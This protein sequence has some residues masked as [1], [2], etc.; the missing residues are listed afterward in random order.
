VTTILEL[1]LYLRVLELTL[2]LAELLDRSAEED[3]EQ[4]C[5]MSDEELE[6]FDNLLS[7]RIEAAR[8]SSNRNDRGRKGATRQMVGGLPFGGERGQRQVRRLAASSNRLIASEGSP[9]VTR[10][11]PPQ[12]YRSYPTAQG[13][14]WFFDDGHTAYVKFE[15]D[16]SPRTLHIGELTFTLRL[17]KSWPEFYEVE[18][19]T[20]VDTMRLLRR[21]ANLKTPPIRWTVRV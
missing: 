20:V 18:E 11:T 5:A 2:S 9:N 16:T 12:L 15:P 17:S 4:L 14:I 7:Q 1:Q 3:A 19:L 10:S 6:A 13:T 21:Y 8:S